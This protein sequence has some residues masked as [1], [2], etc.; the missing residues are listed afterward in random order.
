MML[1]LQSLRE[2]LVSHITTATATSARRWSPSARRRP[3][4]TRAG[5]RTELPPAASDAAASPGR[6]YLIASIGESF[7][8]RSAG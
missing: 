5:R 4:G 3:G 7:A 6:S 8:A 2:W 1:T